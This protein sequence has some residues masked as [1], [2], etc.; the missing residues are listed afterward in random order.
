M[1]PISIHFLI[2]YCVAALYIS[3]KG[4]EQRESP[5]IMHLFWGGKHILT[6]CQGM[7]DFPKKLVVALLEKK[8]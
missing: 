7:F 2:P 5:Q 3:C 8:L 4:R 1:F 6:L